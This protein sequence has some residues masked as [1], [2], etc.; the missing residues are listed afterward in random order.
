[1]KLKVLCLLIIISCKDSGN[2]V[3]FDSTI[4]IEKG[5][6]GLRDGPALKSLNAEYTRILIWD[7]HLIDLYNQVDQ[8]V[9][10]ESIPDYQQIKSISDNGIKIILTLRWPDQ[11]SQD[12][13][14][15]DRVPEDVDRLNSIELLKRFLSD[16]G[17]LI[18]IYSI[19]NEVGGLGPGTYSQEDMESG[20]NS[21]SNAFN[22][23][24]DIVSTIQLEKENSSHLSHLKISSPTP[25]LLKRIVEEPDGLPTT[26][27]DFFYETIVFGNEYCDYIDFHFNKIPLSSYITILEFIKP[28]VDKPMISTEWSEVSSADT[29]INTAISSSYKEKS[30]ELGYSVPEDLNLNSELIDYYYTN[31]VSKELWKYLVSESN[32]EVGFMKESAELLAQYNFK[33]LCWNSGWQEGLTEYDLRSFFATK[34]VQGQDNSIDIFINEFIEL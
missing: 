33:I 7:T 25:I 10:L 20:D 29:F 17:S 24:K 3:D 5:V 32:Y 21:N 26:N 18:E 13:S 11:D 12:A 28:L 22:W 19:Q 1:M 16:F 30:I 6:F 2:I 23:W 27:I 15:Y 31:P 14:L 4:E 9:S 8:G 34:T